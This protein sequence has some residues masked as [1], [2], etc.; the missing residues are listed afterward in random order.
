M[1]RGYD[2]E[3]SILLVAVASVGM[4]I[5][6]LLAIFFG[7]SLERKYL[8]SMAATVWTIA[9]LI[10]A[11]IPSEA[12]I[13]IFG[14]IAAMT[15]SFLIPLLYTYT[16][17]NFPTPFRATGVSI[18]DGI[19]HLGGA[20]CGQ[21]IM[22]VYFWFKAT[23]YGVNAAFTC[24]AVTGALTAVLVLFGIRMNNKQLKQ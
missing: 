18:T 4:I 10:I 1:L 5:G 14:F 7:D 19:G 20:F 3:N 23:G 17:E 2:L 22:G 6:S 13:Y 11:W 8:V 12:I 21:I 24:M 16:A 15:I 9:L